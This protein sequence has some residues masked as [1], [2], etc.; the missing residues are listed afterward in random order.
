MVTH[1]NRR[2]DTYYVHVRNTKTGK[3]RYH[4]S[5]DPD[6]AWEGPLP[7]EY[8]IYENPNGRVFVRRKR[9]SGFTAEEVR[10]VEQHM[11]KR[12]ALKRWAFKVEGKDD[13]ITVH[14]ICQDLEGIVSFTASWM[15][16]EKG[17]MA[18]L[19]AKTGTYE[20][21]M[22]FRLLE[23]GPRT[24][25]AERFCFLGGIDDWMPIG[26]PGELA[27]LAE[28]FARHLGRDSFYELI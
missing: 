20:P 16:K 4:V 15:V 1:T 14:E 11:R 23:E 10:T 2:G 3:N 18:E 19:A 25:Q 24:F 7:D 17:L 22:R 26:D 8:E 12:S 13:A 28:E 6:D 21:M 27:P 5:K 9:A